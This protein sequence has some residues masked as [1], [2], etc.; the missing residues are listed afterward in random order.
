MS[1]TC[2]RNF[3]CPELGLAW[4][5][6]RRNLLSAMGHHPAMARG[7]RATDP[8]INRSHAFFVFCSAFSLVGVRSGRGLGRMAVTGVS[9]AVRTS[10]ASVSPSGW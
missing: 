8:G 5:I 1:R 3:S 10:G 9:A 4:G 2:P 7:L 6:S